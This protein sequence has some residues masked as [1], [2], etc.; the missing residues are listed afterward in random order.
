MDV[1]EEGT[2]LMY[3][4]RVD[5]VTLVRIPSIDVAVDNRLDLFCRAVFRVIFHVLVVR[6]ANV[7]C[8][9]YFSGHARGSLIPTF[10]RRTEETEDQLYL[11]F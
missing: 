7:S 9:C 10:S 6:H 11:S 8:R 3:D 4:G 1:S 5:A 2:D